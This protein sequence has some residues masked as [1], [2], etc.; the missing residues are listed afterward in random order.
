MSTI[1]ARLTLSVRTVE[2]HIYQAMLKTGSSL[3]PADAGR[4][5]PI[6]SVARTRVRSAPKRQAI[7]DHARTLTDDH[8]HLGHRPGQAIPADGAAAERVQ[9]R[10][11]ASQ[12]PATHTDTYTAH[13]LDPKAEGTCAL[14]VG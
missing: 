4:T 6:L 8:K 1:A 14:R 12:V 11:L 10:R 5:K 9:K 2:S 13:T 7:C 3:W